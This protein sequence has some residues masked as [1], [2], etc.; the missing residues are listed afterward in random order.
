MD[1]DDK[2]DLST[3]VRLILSAQGGDRVA[4][5]ALFRRYAPRVLRIAA[6][7][8][9]WTTREFADY[10]DIAQDALVRALKGLDGFD[11]L[12][13]GASVGAFRNW[14]ACCVNSAV[15]QHFRERGAVKRGREV[16]FADLAKEDLSTSIFAGREPSP[17]KVA[18]AAELEKKLEAAILSMQDHYR[19]IVILRQLCGMSYAEIATERGFENEDNVRIILHRALKKLKRALF[20]ND[21]PGS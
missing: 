17:S 9:G 1:S 13:E 18:Q 8:F 6:L 19:D 7:R 2:T 10:E 20:G 15:K 3:T 12:A 4:L 21:T 5:D 16:R 14:L 11:P